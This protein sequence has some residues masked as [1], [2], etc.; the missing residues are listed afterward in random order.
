MLLNSLRICNVPRMAF[1][2]RI[3]FRSN[4]EYQYLTRRTHTVKPINLYTKI[5]DCAIVHHSKFHTTRKLDIPPALAFLVRPL[6]NV[7]AFLFGRYFKRWWARLTPTQKEMYKKWFASKKGVFLGILGAFFSGVG[8]Y[9]VSH[10]E[11]DPLTNRRRLIILNDKQQAALADITYQMNLENVKDKIVSHRHPGFKRIMAVAEKLLNAN[12]DLPFVAD[13]SWTLHVL[14]VEGENAYVLPGGHIFVYLDF[15]K[16]MENDDQIAIILAHEIAHVLLKHAIEKV[17][18]GIILDILLIIPLAALWAMFP[19]LLA[20]FLQSLAKSLLEV[21]LHLPYSRAVEKEADEVGLALAAKACFDVREAVVFWAMMKSLEEMSGKLKELPIVSTHPNH[22]EREKLLNS[23]MSKALELRMLAGKFV[24]H[25]FRAAGVKFTMIKILLLLL[26]P[27]LSSTYNLDVSHPT[28]HQPT[29]NSRSGNSYFGYN[30][31]LHAKSHTAINGST[32]RESW[33]IVGAPKANYTRQPDHGNEISNEP[34]MVYRCLLKGSCFPINVTNPDDE[35]GFIEQV[36][37][38]TL[39]DKDHGWFGAA[40]SSHDDSDSLTVCAPRTIVKIY[41]TFAIVYQNTM[42]GVCYNGGLTSGS[43]QIEDK[44][45]TTFE[46]SSS[47]WYNPLNGFSVHYPS[48]TKSQSRPIRPI[49]GSPKHELYGSVREMGQHKPTELPVSDDLAQ[50][51]YALTSGHFFNPDQIMVAASA[52]GWQYVGQVAV[53]DP[54]TEP[55][56]I[57]VLIEGSVTGE[58][59][60]ASLASGDL[61]KDGLDDLIVGCPHW[62]NDNGRVLIY[63]GHKGGFFEPD[64]VLEGKVVDGLFGYSVTSGDLD[65]DGYDEI[66]VGAPWEE[67]GV[68]Y[69][70]NG[71]AKLQEFNML[72]AS[73]K[74]VATSDEFQRFG[75]SLSRPVDMDGNGFSDLGVGAYASG[76]A[77]VLY[78]RPVLKTELTLTTYPLTLPRNSTSFIVEVCVS[79]YI[80]NKPSMWPFECE[81][82]VDEDFKRVVYKSSNKMVLTWKKPPHGKA[83]DNTT[84]YLSTGSRNFIDV[85]EIVVIHRLLNSS[86]VSQLHVEKCELCPIEYKGSHSTVARTKLPFDIGCGM[87]DICQSFLFAKLSL[88][89]VN[90]STWIIGSDDLSLE[91]VIGNHA[92]PA[93]LATVKFYIPKGITLRSILPSCQE[94]TDGETLLVICDIGNPLGALMQKKVSLDLDMNRMH[95]GSTDGTKLD[96]RVDISTRSVNRG[97]VSI[98]TPLLLKANVSVALTGKAHDNYYFNHQ[99]EKP[100]N[101]TFQHTYQVSRYGATPIF[102]ARIS[103][104]VPYKIGDLEFLTITNKPRVAVLGRFHECSVEAVSISPPQVPMDKTNTNKF[105]E[106][107]QLNTFANHTRNRRALKNVPTLNT[108]AMMPLVPLDLKGPTSSE[109]N[110][111]SDFYTI[112]DRSNAAEVYLNC[113]TPNV[114][115]GRIVCNLAHL[116][117]SH[118]VGKLQLKFLIDNSKFTDEAEENGKFIY[119][120]TEAMLEVLSPTM[121]FD[122]P[123]TGIV[124]PVTTTFHRAQGV[125]NVSIWIILGSVLLG[126]LTLLV[127]VIILNRIGFFKR[128]RKE[129]L[130]ELKSS[131]DIPLA[132]ELLSCNE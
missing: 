81:A 10:L 88:A 110:I 24:F 4:R 52:P 19:D 87:D 127:L 17:S 116:K 23:K 46:F 37:L 2:L 95:N 12:N 90:D 103:V 40:I 11:T 16:L 1:K 106:M 132:T 112:S 3:S 35:V 25:H 34:G 117:S 100:S 89:N 13:E 96:F 101:V 20:F 47:F 113:S 45:F 33:V 39:I 6:V 77:I 73:Q 119:F 91:L 76:H 32:I 14:D 57:V 93:Y 131:D 7:A 69:V 86:Y 43:L 78:S 128:K 99:N 129:E 59:F 114:K 62:K 130:D 50:F 104:R 64:V 18:Y 98:A 68:I 29:A 118:D 66:I 83:C 70:Y 75:F 123:G 65:G 108:N 60:G 124:V 51:G 54:R 55:M 92:E 63:F 105:E 74:I 126:L 30:V 21:F 122:V 53:M 9:Y 48:Q 84:F 38:N 67:S 82:T 61:N 15:L 71:E 125:K 121:Q 72:E 31:I 42:H 107:L 79:N 85:I 111:R 120:S 58:F 44:N 22:A 27:S 26:L 36:Q 41:N 49:I 56:A 94:D 115:C 5:K 28:V 97:I 102:E 80:N 8:L 109:N